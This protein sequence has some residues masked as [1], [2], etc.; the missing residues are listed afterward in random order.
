MNILY[1]LNIF[2]SIKIGFGEKYLNSAL[3]RYWQCIEPGNPY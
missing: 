2:I 3:H 1:Q